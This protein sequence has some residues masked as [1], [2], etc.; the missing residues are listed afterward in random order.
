MDIRTAKEEKPKFE[1]V[2]FSNLQRLVYDRACEGTYRRLW[3][4]AGAGIFL[5]IAAIVASY[6]R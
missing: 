4:A 1:D 6:L 3:L 5:A 2:R